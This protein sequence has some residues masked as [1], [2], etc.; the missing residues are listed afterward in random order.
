MTT[1]GFQRRLTA[2][3]NAD[4]EGYSRLTTENRLAYNT[5]QQTYLR[6]GEISKHLNNMA[7]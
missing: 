7:L 1:E 3:L 6:D 5:Q 2:I 4:A